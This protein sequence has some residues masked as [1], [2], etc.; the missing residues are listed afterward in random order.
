[1]TSGTERAIDGIVARGE[2]GGRTVQIVESG[3]VECHAYPAAPLLDGHVRVRTVRSAISPGTEMTFFGRDATNVYLH[4]RWNEE[5][6]LFEPGVPSME[7]PV[8]FGYRASG[9]VV[10]SRADSVPVGHRVYGNW[11]H[12]ELSEMPAQRAL[13]QTLPDDLSWDDGA[14]VGQ[15]GPICVNA[16]AF[17]EQEHVGEPVVV[18]GAGPVGL[19]TAQVARAQGAGRVYV[20]DRLA[21]RLAV[22]E[23]LGLEPVEAAEGVDV[24]VT[25]KRRHGSE[26]IPVALECTGS[27]SALNE[28]IRVVKRRGLVVAAGFYQGEGRGLLLGDEF[29]HNGVRV[30]CGQ[31]G[32]VHP[33]LSWPELRARTIAIARSGSV[34]LGG[35]PR[36]TVPVERIAE[37]FDALTRPAEVLQVAV[38]YEPAG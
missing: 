14:D 18:F 8:V 31:I 16:F 38:S 9:E 22:A 24:A 20:V 17:V 36:M 15:M 37:G 28:A 4:K 2:I 13:D 19:I 12:T 23:S 5:L 7:Y 32:N 25:L 27:T 3:A 26:G 29:H 6:R 33:T 11:R 35:L 34:V 30:I 10:E 21:N 1:M